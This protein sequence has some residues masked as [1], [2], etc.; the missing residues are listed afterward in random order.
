MIGRTNAVIGGGNFTK[1]VIIVTAPTG[2]TVTCSNGS[3]VKK[4]EEKNGTWIF[5][6]LDAGTW[7]VTATQGTKVSAKE[8]GVAAN[9]VAFVQLTYSLNLLELPES[10]WTEYLA[11]SIAAWND[12]GSL[13]MTQKSSGNGSRWTMLSPLVNLTNY[14]T[15]TLAVTHVSG[16]ETDMIFGV[17]KINQYQSTGAAAANSFKTS[18][19]YTLDISQLSGEFYCGLYSVGKNNTHVELFTKLELS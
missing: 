3:T 17:T 13:E 2:S 8:V 10:E 9:T 6:G 16:T 1:S 14:D 4:A 18:G 12:D 7:T 15:L 19:L 11:S 5:G